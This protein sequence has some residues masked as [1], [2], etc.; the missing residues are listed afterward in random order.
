MVKFD[1]IPLLNSTDV[2]PIQFELQRVFERLAEERQYHGG[3]KNYHSMVVAYFADLSK[4]FQ[5]LR[6]VCA[7]GSEVLFIVGDSAPYG[8]YVPVDRWLGELALAAGFETYDFTKLRDRNLKWKNR[9][10]RVPL[11]E[12]ILRVRG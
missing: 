10:H 9:K 2:A 3:K 7:S 12:G 4:I 5:A 11:H 8:V 6:R 1:P